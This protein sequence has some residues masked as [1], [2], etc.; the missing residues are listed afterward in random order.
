MN[1]NSVW[2]KNFGGSSDDFAY[3]VQQTSD[4][5]YIIAGSYSSGDDDVYLIRTD[6]NGILVWNMTYGSSS[7]DDYGKSI[8]QTTDGGFIVTGSYGTSSY[9]DICLIKTYSNGV[10]EWTKTFGGTYGQ[11]GESVKQT[12]DGG[13][14][15]FGTT[16]SYG[17]GLT[18][19]YFI[20]TD[21][22]GNVQ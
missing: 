15:I 7:E 3:S 22:S 20:K 19:F 14:A 10:A 12:S 8:Q 16:A 11:I 1:G 17:A 4:G 5:G 18:D 9:N 13:Y 2:T 21:V 6:A